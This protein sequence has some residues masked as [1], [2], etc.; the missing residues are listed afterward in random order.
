MRYQIVAGTAHEIL[1][2]KAWLDLIALAAKHGYSA[3][4]LGHLGRNAATDLTEEEAVGLYVTLERV[5]TTVALQEHST[6]EVDVLD[7]DTVHRVRRVLRQPAP[8]RL[9]R[10]RRVLRQPG[11]KRLRRTPPWR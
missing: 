8:K 1:S 7:R 5:L 9:Y 2:D 3:P 6:T 4:R 11:L 10:V